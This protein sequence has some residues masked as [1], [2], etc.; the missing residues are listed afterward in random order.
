[1]GN[2]TWIE[3]HVGEC[4]QN[5]LSRNTFLRIIAPIIDEAINQQ[6]NQIELE[7]RIAEIV[8][9]HLNRNDEVAETIY[10]VNGAV[11]YQAK[12]RGL[13]TFENMYLFLSCALIGRFFSI[14]SK[15]IGYIS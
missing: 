2:A 4:V 13:P 11:V 1:M 3:R 8:R 9:R 7:I 6:I 14:T 5:K 10:C 15:R 12:D